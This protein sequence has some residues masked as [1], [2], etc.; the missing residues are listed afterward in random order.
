MTTASIVT[1]NTRKEDLDRVLESALREN[2]ARL[3]VIDHSPTDAIRSLLP[4]DPRIEYE[5]RPNKGYGAGH[6]AAIRK[7]MKAGAKY[8]AVL[9]PDIYWDGNVIESLAEYMDAHPG[10]GDML[11]K[12]LYPD[13]RLQYT[14]KLIPPPFDLIAHRFLP[15]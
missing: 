1:Y 8:H 7:A 5:K 2:V 11:P 4:P 14:C 13:G 6:N 10:V 15:E 9:N 12:V 3:Y